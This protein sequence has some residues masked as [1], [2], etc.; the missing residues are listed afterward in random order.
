MTTLSPRT[1]PIEPTPVGASH[2][3]AQA[4]WAPPGASAAVQHSL[5]TESA[6]ALLGCLQTALAAQ[7]WRSSAAEV[8][9]EIA[10]RLHGLRVSIGW[11]VAGQ[12]RIVALSDGV[13]LEEGAAIPELNQAMLESVHQHATLV[14]PQA[15]KS[16]SRITLAH[17]TLF[18]AQGL[19][20]VLS[21]PLACQGQVIGVITCERS[22]TAES[23]R[24][25]AQQELIRGA[26]EAHEV[27]WLEV[28]A[29]GLAPLLQLQYRLHR[30]WSER[31]RADVALFKQRL[32]DP[33]ERRLR[34]MMVA[35]VLTLAYGLLWPMP[36]RVSATARLEGSVQRV[37]SAAQDGYLREVH[38]RPGDVV[39]QG[40]LLAELSDDDLQSTRR[41]RLAE[42]AQQE[43][44]FAE[45]FARGD[46]AQAAMAQS[47]VAESKAQLGLVE[48]QLLRVRLTAPFDGV[49]IAG[50]L[51]Q[52][53]GAP[54]KRGDPLLTLAPG[55]DWRVVL[56]VDESDVSELHRGQ[57]ASLR[58]AAI[59]GQP[60]AL[61]LDR[62][63]PVART[64]AEG[65]RYEV[66]ARPTGVGAGMSGL[67]PGLQG[68][69]KVDLAE[70]PVLWRWSLKVWQ[71]ARMVVWT[72]L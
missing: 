48:Q 55:L 8:V 41:A 44:T 59:P 62:I 16:A 33:A 39:K 71:W 69:A 53:L 42:V 37:L 9:S 58:L 14:W 21:V 35:L 47:K 60:I 3:S 57:T 50:D 38:V 26:F 18:K 64:T 23:L 19:A 13:V 28:V 51:H 45:A 2:G 70:R 10:Q 5:A 30:P 63:T 7:D 56:E 68:I 29:E 32:R 12:L 36:Y 27:Q 22:V 4:T 49:V 65:V 20:G 24:P 43:N 17:Q 66:E 52:Q 61:V 1:A 15:A 40:Q 34:W 25:S 6:V 72:W 11:V 46:R 31:A 54:V 67:R